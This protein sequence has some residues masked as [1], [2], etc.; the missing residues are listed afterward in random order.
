[1]YYTLYGPKFTGSYDAGLTAYGRIS[2]PTAPSQTIDPTLFSG[3]DPGNG[4]QSLNA[5]LGYA[6]GSRLLS[7][8]RAYIP[9]GLYVRETIP[10]AITPAATP[11][12]NPA[13][14]DGADPDAIRAGTG[15]PYGY[16][17]GFTILETSTAYARKSLVLQGPLLGSVTCTLTNRGYCRT[18]NSYPLS[19]KGN[20]RVL[21]NYGPPE[22][23]YSRI[24]Q[25]CSPFQQ[26][27]SQILNTYLDTQR[28][29]AQLYNEMA[30][31]Q[32]GY[33]GW[34]IVT[35]TQAQQGKAHWL[36]SFV[37]TQQ[38][39]GRVLLGAS[40]SQQGH[41]QIINRISPTQKGKYQV[42]N[43][44]TN[45]GQR[46]YSRALNTVSPAQQG[47]YQSLPG[48]H[49]VSQQGSYRVKLAVDNVCQ[50]GY[51]RRIETMLNDQLGRYRLANNAKEGYCLYV[52]DGVLPILNGSPQAFA[53]S[54]PFSYV[55]TPPGSGTKTFYTVVRKRN[56]YGLESQ[57]QKP[58]LL[59]VNSA[60]HLIRNALDAPANLQLAAM[61]NAVLRVS[62]IYPLAGDDPFPADKWRIWVDVSPPNTALTPTA[63][64]AVAGNILFLDMTPFT[65]GT[66]FVAVA[67]YRTIDTYTS[68]VTS[69]TLIIPANPFRPKPVH[70][71]FDLEI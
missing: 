25:G 47:Y 60:G 20:G 1:M 45:S 6:P 17:P 59:I 11:S 68:P 48:A 57:N 61:P 7:K 53:A 49:F 28:G 42:Y 24:L 71:G 52:G 30:G 66:Y 9:Q 63:E 4:D 8:S 16:V 19:Q 51:C 39:N 46:G 34:V 38:G 70:S 58:S 12:P 36:N 10:T 5:T 54:L 33:A 22:T 65:P 18:V 35:V 2:A 62:A 26:G 3:G 37:E 50:L 15:T 32:Q 69:A 23:G 27:H 31:S 67:L 13:I 56:K 41:S 29:V 14:L 40:P 64:V 44:L 43:N 21:N 55:V